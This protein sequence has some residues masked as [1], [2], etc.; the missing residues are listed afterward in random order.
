MA[1]TLSFSDLWDK[2]GFTAISVAKKYSEQE[3]EFMNNQ[4]D[5][6]VNRLFNPVL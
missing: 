2:A 3:I 4:Y 5:I 6:K 1:V